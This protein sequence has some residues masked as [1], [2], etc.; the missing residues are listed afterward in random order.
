MYNTEIK[1]VKIDGIWFQIQ[2][3]FLWNCIDGFRHELVNICGTV[4]PA[5]FQDDPEIGFV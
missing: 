4:V 3:P 1:Q 2:S 5:S